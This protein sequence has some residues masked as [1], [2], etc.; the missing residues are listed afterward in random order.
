MDDERAR[1]AGQHHDDPAEEQSADAAVHYREH[2]LRTTMDTMLEGC[3]VLDFELRYLYVN[4]AA[5]RQNRR[6]K[7]ELL[8]RPYQDVWPGIEQ[9]E[10]YRLV[11][12]CL[13]ERVVQ[14]MENEF[15][16]PDGAVGRFELI[17]QPVPEGVLIESLDITA[18]REAEREAEEL[19]A[20]VRRE[21]DR[22]AAL[23]A[24]ISDEI[25]FADA[26]GRFTLANPA[27]ER[28]FRLS[29]ADE[30]PV[31]ELAASLQVL[32]ADGTPRPVEE[33][34]PLRALAGETVRNAEEL[35]RT[36]ATGELRRRLVNSTPVRDAGGAIVGSVSV[37]RD[38]TELRRAE[39]DLSRER[40]RARTYADIAGVML[41]AIAPDETVGFV[42]RMTCEVLGRPEE[43]IVGRSWF[44][45]ALPDS[46]RGPIR[47]GF[48]QLMADNVAPWEYVEN[49]VCTSGGEERLIAWHNRVLK[50]ER[51][52]IVA[53]LSSGE[54]ITERRRI[55]E[56][57]RQSEEHF[58]GLVENMPDALAR[59]D[60]ERRVTYV[61]PAI[62]CYMTS[63][64]QR[65]VG[66]T[67]RE[68][69]LP[70]HLAGALDDALARALD[71]S[72][73]V[74]VEAAVTTARGELQLEVRVFPELDAEGRPS[75]AVVLAH[76]ITQRTR[77]ERA[78]RDSET[79]Y[80]IVADNTYDW[81]WWTAP[82]GS[83]VYV[84][85]AC[86]R[87]TGHTPEEF[88]ARADLLEEITHADDR[89]RVHAH[90]AEGAS[91]AAEPHELVFRLLTPAGDERVIEHRCMPV[92]G[93][94]GAYLGR[95]GS[96]RDITERR[97]AEEE[98]RRL[99]AELKAR[100]VSRTEQFDAATRE[101]EALAYSI[102]HDV[103]TPLRTIDGFSALAVAD[104]GDRLGPQATAELERV[105]RAAQTLGRLMDDLLGLSKVSQQPLERSQV[106]VTR[107]AAEVGAEIAA[108]QPG[109]AVDLTVQPGLAAEADPALLR[110]ILRQL[111]DNAW[112]FTAGRSPAHVQ[113]G[114]AD[115]DGE[116]V[117]FVRDDGV[118]FD[119]DH[120]QHLFGV[121]Q[122]Q[123]PPGAFAGDGVGL[124][125]VQ[126]LVRRHGG[127]VW[128][129]AKVDG[130]ATLSFT[131]PPATRTG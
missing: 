58:R 104:A 15:R 113:V 6:P 121:F 94:D 18:R 31:R 115:E 1:D 37:V 5:E 80:R 13:E 33:A 41:V 120:A 72:V 22:L 130:G 93:A 105:R 7:E 16:F 114:A 112:K 128:A 119:M 131:L 97:R 40:D 10:V 39:E 8:G 116:R 118:G 70:Q 124:A 67:N 125:T 126:R 65:V 129:E 36:P 96:N 17:M 42:N 109:R 34:P 21:R 87:I 69:G 45:V 30:T 66:R 95:R 62:G 25:W 111:L 63:D 32:R 20:Q 92:Y 61:S 53:T 98:I 74:E 73:T 47:E 90:I 4:D 44:D 59:Y 2:L 86:A 24:S 127:R 83:Y 56:T 54:D 64:P 26:G 79:K 106:D 50:D 35:I 89:A 88:L 3:Q 110:L 38:V 108:E 76:D 100:V 28:E 14:R 103:R 68:A 43:E 23:V 84:S 57:L 91:D 117:F 99:N 60:L 81:E 11:R 48:A 85:P 46:V 29:A 107:L 77:A 27:A 78:L 102:A 19:Q 82:D 122:R 123:H 49:P 51:G 101:L 9:T 52:A 75:G 71:S 12:R 55:E